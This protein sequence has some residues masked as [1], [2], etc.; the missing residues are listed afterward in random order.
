MNLKAERK[1]IVECKV[2]EWDGDIVRKI[3]RWYWT[4]R[5]KK[6]PEGEI[7]KAYREQIRESKPLAWLN[8]G[9]E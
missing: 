2:D 8:G 1:Y 7:L 5:V 3:V 9:E 4:G 6:M